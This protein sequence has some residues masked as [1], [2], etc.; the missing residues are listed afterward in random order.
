[1]DQVITV[2]GID[3]GDKKSAY[4]LLESEHGKSPSDWQIVAKDVIDNAEL[5]I[6]IDYRITTGGGPHHIII[7]KI[8]SYNQKVGATVFDTVKWT[9]R[10]F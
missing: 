2:I 9:G 8:V 4:V 5:K 10:F 7:E 6:L 1:M 3:P